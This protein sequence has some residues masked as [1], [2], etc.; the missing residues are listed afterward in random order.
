MHGLELQPSYADLARQNAAANGTDA[1]VHEGDVR[2]MPAA[3][4]ERSFDAVMLNPPWRGADA[5][6]SPDPGRDIARRLGTTLAVW[7]A[8]ALSRT[9]PGGR[10]VLIQRAERL[11]EILDGLAGRAGGIA[12]LPLVARAGRDA[13][14]VIVKARKGSKSPFRLAAPLVLHLGSA[15]LKDGDD[16]TE[17]ARAILR[18]AAPLNF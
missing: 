12:V 11:P 6:G 9:R 4:K 8:A 3:L 7:L 10:V 5:P 13:K 14:R 16:H 18:D 17:A 1:I 15:H 2:A